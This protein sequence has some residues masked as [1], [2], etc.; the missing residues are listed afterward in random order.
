M[1]L[2]FLAVIDYIW[3]EKNKMIILPKMICVIKD[4]L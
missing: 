4:I 2:C 3:D 1:K